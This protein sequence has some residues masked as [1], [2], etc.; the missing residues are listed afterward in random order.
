MSLDDGIQWFKNK[1]KKIENAFANTFSSSTKEGYSSILGA[2]DIDK[3]NGIESAATTG[4]TTP[5]N[6]NVSNY[7]STNESLKQKTN[8]YLNTIE[9]TQ[10]RNYNVYVN[11]AVD[12]DNFNDTVNPI[13]C[14]TS[15]ILTN[16]GL[17]EVGPEFYS[18]AYKTNFNSYRDAKQACKL[19]AG[20]SGKSHFALGKSSDNSKFQCYTGNSLTGTLTQYTVPQVA[21][22]IATSDDATAGGLF[23]DGTI[24]V[25]NSTSTSKTA[26]LMAGV[27]V[28]SGYSM[29]D[30]WVGGAINASSINA[31]LGANCSGLANEP[32]NARYI[33]IRANPF[34]T[35]NW[36]QI[37]QVAVYVYDPVTGSRKNVAPSGSVTNGRGGNPSY[38][39][40]GFDY[41]SPNYNIQ[42]SINGNLSVRNY[43]FYHSPYTGIPFP[44]WPSSP[45]EFWTLDLKQD[46][47]VYQVV[48]YGRALEPQ[49]TN[50]ATLVLENGAKTRQVI[51][52]M[53]GQTVQ[54]YNIA[55]IDSKAELII[56]FDNVGRS[57][58]WADSA[59]YAQSKGG[60]LATMPEA[61]DYITR[62][63]GGPLVPN[64]DVWAAVTPGGWVKQNDYVQVGNPP[65]PASDWG[66]NTRATHILAYGVG[67]WFTTLFEAV[68]N[69]HVLWVEPAATEAATST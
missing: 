29:C 59:A 61:Q 27:T 66:H 17:V 41:N 51:K 7:N 39:T 14:A 68:F 26:T 5:F 2:N 45:Y 15:D 62:Q 31:T 23:Y 3:Q 58:T 37:S 53:T 40:N 16:G 21:T 55:D 32:F 42:H 54:T 20:D 24:G 57:L 56:H 10:G 4:L 8:T 33:T 35:D 69:K 48:Y 65:H 49:R 34:T 9:N 60:R 47:P 50:G 12:V 13:K 64:A 52:P 38:G 25:Y 28:P 30:K 6:T 19:W 67:G 44:W 36:L 22:T 1:T 63:G 18:T 43:N 11:K 46:Y